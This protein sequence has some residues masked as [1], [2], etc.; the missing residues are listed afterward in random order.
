MLSYGHENHGQP[1][2]LVVDPGESPKRISIQGERTEAWREDW[3]AMAPV[4]SIR[5][6]LADPSAEWIG[7]SEAKRLLGLRTEHTVK[8]W[9]RNGLLRSKTAPNGQTLVAFE[10]VLSRAHESDA[11]TT[12]WDAPV[13]DEE[14]T[15][16]HQTRPGTAPGRRGKTQS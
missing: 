2:T 6:L 12:P 11:L 7:P 15:I 16:L 9:A 5:E 14:A 4:E 13:T 1:A 8:A 10:D 3:T